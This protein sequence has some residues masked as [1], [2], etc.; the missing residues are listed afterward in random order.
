V[1]S[2]GLDQTVHRLPVWA[3]MKSPQGGESVMVIVGEGG[4]GGGI[5]DEEV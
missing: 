2:R 3:C 4:E 1:A 5:S